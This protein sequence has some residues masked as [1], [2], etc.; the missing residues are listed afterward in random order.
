MIGANDMPD[1]IWAI[2]LPEDHPGHR[3]EG[4]WHSDPGAF[5]GVEYRRAALMQA[6]QPA[7]EAVSVSEAA[8]LDLQY[9]ANDLSWDRRTRDISDR[10]LAALRALKGD[11][12]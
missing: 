2:D 4:S 1:R 3:I 6:R 12:A 9:L 7:G 5:G 8:L 10:I 11:A